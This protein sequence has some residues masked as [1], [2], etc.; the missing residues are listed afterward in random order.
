METLKRL[1]QGETEQAVDDEVSISFH[2]DPTLVKKLSAISSH[3]GQ[4]LKRTSTL[5]NTE[6][7]SP[8]KLIKTMND[9]L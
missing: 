8:S 5:P 1:S 7:L 2:R 3:S 6:Q 4:S 9:Q